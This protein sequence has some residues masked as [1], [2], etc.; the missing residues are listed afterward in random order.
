MNCE[1]CGNENV[2]YTIDPYQE[3]IYGREVYVWLCCDCY[4]NLVMSI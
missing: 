1:D 3:E 2:D 4:S